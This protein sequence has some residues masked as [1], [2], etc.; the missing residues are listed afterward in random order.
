MTEKPP[1]VNI[2]VV[3]VCKHGVRMVCQ[4]CLDELH[5]DLLN[6]TRGGLA[7]EGRII[8]EPGNGRL[9]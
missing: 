6:N 2:E 8:V 1:G 9:G 5:D 7:I 4:A 3:D